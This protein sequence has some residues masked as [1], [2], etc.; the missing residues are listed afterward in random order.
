MTL[1]EKIKR[2]RKSGKMSRKRFS[3]KSGVNYRTLENIEMNRIKNPTIGTLQ[4]IAMALKMPVDALLIKEDGKGIYL[5]VPQ[6]VLRAIE[7]NASQ[8]MLRLMKET[9]AKSLV[10]TADFLLS[11]SQTESL[12]RGERS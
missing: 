2:I 4:K 8:N 5:Y 6:D 9:G 1:G 3:K 7:D 12:Q 10:A 11:L